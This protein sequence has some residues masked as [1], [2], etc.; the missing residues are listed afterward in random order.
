MMKRL[1][2]LVLVAVIAIFILLRSR[3]QNAR[4]HDLESLG[5]SLK[6]LE[7]DIDDAIAFADVPPFSCERFSSSDGMRANCYAGLSVTASRSREE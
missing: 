7:A 3:K 6:V 4:Q 2:A 5:A 1:F